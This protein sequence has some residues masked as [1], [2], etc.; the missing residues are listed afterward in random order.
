MGEPLKKLTPLEAVFV[1]PRIGFMKI[2]EILPYRQYKLIGRVVN[3]PTEVD[4]SIKILPRL[5]SETQTIAVGLK[6]KMNHK[7]HYLY[8]MVRPQVIIDAA[9]YLKNSEVYKYLNIQ[10]DEIRLLRDFSHSLDTIEEIGEEIDNDLTEDNFIEKEKEPSKVP[11]NESLVASESIFFSPGENQTPLSI[12]HDKYAECMSFV[13]L[14]NGELVDCPAGMTYQQFCKSRLTRN[15]RRFTDVTSLLYM[16]SKLRIIKISQQVSLC[17]RKKQIN[18]N[19]ITAENITNKNY[20][21][22]ALSNNEAYYKLFS[23]DR[24]SPSF[25]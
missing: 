19:D 1:S 13:K 16:S 22:S 17:L 6:R 20:L 8:E 12:I 24:G 15:D 14:Y 4:K 5:P 11:C 2:Q 7:N 18:Q 23:S 10:I 21:S 9:N 3:V 25:T